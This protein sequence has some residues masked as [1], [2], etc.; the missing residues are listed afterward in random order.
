MKKGKSRLKRTILTMVLVPTLIVYIAVNVIA[1]TELTGLGN[2]LVRDE[3]KSNTYE[4]IQTLNIMS[5]E[6]YTY[7]NGQLKKGEIN[8]SDA[9][10]M[11]DS[12]K[13]N[14]DIEVSIYWG[15]INVVTSIANENQDVIGFTV[16]TSIVDQVQNGNNTYYDEKLKIGDSTYASYFTPLTQSSGEVVGML[17]VGKSNSITSNKINSL[18]MNASISIIFAIVVI[19]FITSMV[20]RRMINSIRASVETMTNVSGG[21]LKVDIP[22]KVLKRKDEIGDITRGIQTIVDSFKDIIEKILTSS[23]QLGNM[24]VEFGE[25]FKTV[26]KMIADIEHAV[27]EIANGATT[28]ASETQNASMN[29]QNIGEEIDSTSEEIRR[30]TVSSEK[31]KQY[32][33]TANETMG[34]LLKISNTTH[35]AMVSIQEQTNLTHESV[36][37]IQ[38][39]VDIISDIAEQTNLLS[40]NASI[41]AARAGENGK[42]FAVVADEIRKLA[43]QCGASAQKIAG[44]VSA[45]MDN[46]INSVEKMSEVKEI[47]LAQN[48]KINN[49]KD[50]FSRV[51]D[52]IDM[53]NESINQMKDRIKLLA[54]LKTSVL[55]TI[56]GLAAIAEENAASTEETNASMLQLQTII[57]GCIESA[58]SLVDLSDELLEN[59]KRFSM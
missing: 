46:S 5:A 54:E 53:V 56:E 17:C 18:F 1:Y 41:E 21:I 11:V 23:N 14:C 24:S 22:E 52:E 27:D 4:I 40:L 20:T 8:L 32:S 28:Q 37:E 25:N 30:L 38:T 16:D 19:F 48:D 42:G 6:D 47:V 7:E 12:L 26:A 13:E 50:L 9:G 2:D 15:D 35:E 57:D 58:Q 49:T 55:V 34:E 51:S 31:M 39:T 44:N 10:S 45:L 36:E 3:L 59:T 29:I 43:D 33:D